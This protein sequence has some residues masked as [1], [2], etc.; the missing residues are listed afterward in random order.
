MNA[1]LSWDRGAGIRRSTEEDN[2]GRI[3]QEVSVRVKEAIIGG[4]RWS[5][6]GQDLPTL[7]LGLDSMYGAVIIERQCQKCSKSILFSVNTRLRFP[8]DE[9]IADS[10]NLIPPALR[11][12]TKLEEYATFPGFMEITS[13]ATAATKLFEPQEW[14]TYVQ[15]GYSLPKVIWI[16]QATVIGGD[17]GFP[18]SL[19]AELSL[20]YDKNNDFLVEKV[21]LGDVV[22]LT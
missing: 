17:V 16:L 1:T 15:N 13:G 2:C 10:A 11:E 9:P 12:K 21:V 8:S 7:V 19:G 14:R 3:R 22:R 18:F 4:E 20:K 6:G 5:T